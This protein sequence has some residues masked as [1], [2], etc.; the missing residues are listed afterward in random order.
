M[1][2]IGVP[3]VIPLS[4]TKLHVIGVAIPAGQQAVFAF[5]DYGGQ[6]QIDV[7]LGKLPHWQ[8][9]QNYENTTVYLREAITVT[10]SAKH[11]PDVPIGVAKG[12][13]KHEDFQLVLTNTGSNDSGGL[14]ITLTFG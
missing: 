12:G 10:I 3:F 13:T 4:Q 1:P 6:G 8:T 14:E 5:D 11:K 2:I 7:Y 9:Y